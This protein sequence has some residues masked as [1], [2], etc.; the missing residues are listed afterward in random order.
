ML[1]SLSC[2]QVR[3]TIIPVDAAEGD[4]TSDSRAAGKGSVAGEDAAR[5]R[6]V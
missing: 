3:A 1:S 5:A 6:K 4:S 2:G